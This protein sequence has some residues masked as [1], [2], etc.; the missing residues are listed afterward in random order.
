M[1]VGS[2][3]YPASTVD[4][5]PFKKNEEEKRDHYIEFEEFAQALN[6]TPYISIEHWYSFSSAATATH[7]PATPTI[8]KAN[9]RQKPFHSPQISSVHSHMC[10]PLLNPSISKLTKPNGRLYI[11]TSLFVWEPLKY[12]N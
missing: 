6:G 12:S 10:R 8:M 4:T 3:L 2:G 9:T 7:T 11:R 1:G 5:S